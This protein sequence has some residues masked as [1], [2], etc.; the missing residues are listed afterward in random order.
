MNFE[1]ILFPVDFSDESRRVAT[2]V[3]AVAQHF[4]SDLLMLHVMQMLPTW[5]DPVTMDMLISLTDVDEYRRQRR[6]QLEAFANDEFAGMAV[7]RAL[8]QGDPAGQIIIHAGTQQIDLIMMATHGSGRFRA[9]LPGSVTSQVLHDAECPVWTAAHAD[10]PA[11]RP[12]ERWR[13]ILCAVDATDAD[14]GI[15][16]WAAELAG[17]EVAD[18][19]IVHAIQ[20]FGD[21]SDLPDHLRQEILDNLRGKLAR[22]DGHGRVSIQFGA[23]ERVVRNVATD[24]EADLVVIGRG[25]ITKPL[26]RLRS[27]ALAIIRES[28]CP[29]ISL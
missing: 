5:Y 3:R 7:T 24:W 13:R 11:L 10:N 1:H 21:A 26:G 4:R 19:C 15:A 27:R 2:F 6:A 9:L 14:L 23:P 22:F 18:L 8:V 28:P 25:V 17:K 12:A 20:G 29:V 16:R